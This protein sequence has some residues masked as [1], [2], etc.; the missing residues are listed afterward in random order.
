M[1]AVNRLLI[2]TP[3]RLALPG[4]ALGVSVAVAAPW[5]ERIVGLRRGWFTPSRRAAFVA[6]ETAI[7]AALLSPAVPRG[8]SLTALAASQLF[9]LVLVLRLHRRGDIGRRGLLL[10]A[11]AAAA[12]AALALG[13]S[14]RQEGL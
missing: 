10:I 6:R 5:C 12:T 11:P 2:P 4:V 14:R 1:T 13:L 3:E 9:D 8:S 7:V